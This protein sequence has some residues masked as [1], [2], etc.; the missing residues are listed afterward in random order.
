MSSPWAPTFEP[1]FVVGGAAS[2][3]A[4]ARAARSDPPGRARIAAFTAG[5]LLIVLALNSPLETIAVDYLLLFHLL[6]NVII[7]DWAPPLLILGLTPGMRAGIAGRGGRPLAFFT[8]PAIALPIWLIGWYAVHLGG[9]YD[10]AL[11]N[12]ILLNGEHLFMIAIGLLFWWPVL[13]DAPRAVPT[14]GRIAYIFAAFVGSA[15]LGLALTFAPPLYGYY[16]DLPVRLW[17]I[18]AAQDQNLGGI[19]MTTEQ[20]IVFFAMITWLLVVLF[21]EEDEAERELQAR[22][23]AEGLL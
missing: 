15:F 3:W 2:A 12:P 8:R 1:L 11:R 20:A 9:V 19:L 10:A 7:S 6:Q 4:Y 5:I 22:Q 17:G 23:R 16:E 13:S 18:S 14:L 21:R